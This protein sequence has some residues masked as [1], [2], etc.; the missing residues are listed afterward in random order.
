MSASALLKRNWLW[1][2]LVLLCAFIA[3]AAFVAP[4]KIASMELEREATVAATRIGTE[5]KA[6]PGTLIDAF[7]RPSLAPHVSRIFD[8]FGY[9]H[10]VLRYELYDNTGTLTFTS[11]K[12]DLKL[13]QEAGR[14]PHASFPAEPKVTVHD[15]AN[16]AVSHL[17][18]LTLPTRMSGQ[19][20]G[21]LLV[22]LDQSEQAKA[23]SRYFGLIAAVTLLLLGAGVATPIA[24]AWT[25]TG[26]G[27]RPKRSSSKA[28][29]RRCSGGAWSSKSF[30]WRSAARS[31]NSS[32][33]R[34][35]ISPPARKSASR[36]WSA[37]TILC[38]ARSR[39]PISS[40]WRRIPA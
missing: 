5:L 38:M 14:V 23:L 8:K 24:L 15:R 17:A 13:D 6:E 21:T 4:S 32:I 10:R 25:R 22:Y 3:Y 16:A 28:W 1:L 33:S 31:S 19:P 11:G 30:G 20:D 37:G 40:P 9:G 18:V 35:T 2:G 39:P 29:I 26:S 34:N 12:A 36:R 27:A 7:A